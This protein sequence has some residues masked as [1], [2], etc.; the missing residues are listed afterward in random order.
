MNHKSIF[1][2]R[3]SSVNGFTLI[4][5]MVVIGIAGLIFVIVLTSASTARKRARD[6]ERISSFAEIKKALEL[7]YADNQMSPPVSGWAYSTDFS[8][9]EL[10]EVLKPYL[11]AFPKDPQNSA[12]GPWNDGNY[13]YAFNTT[14]NSQEYDL[15]TQLE[16]QSNDNICA[17]KCY[18]FHTEGLGNPWCGAECGGPFRY[19]KY[20][21]ADH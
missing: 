5:L 4:E 7:Y 10:G 18:L 13:S 3:K 16:D 11:R 21:Y 1:V 2:N 12:P 6:A 14:A 8:W 9:D 20:L 15:V 17:K 19:T